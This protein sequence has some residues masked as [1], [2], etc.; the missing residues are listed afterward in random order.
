[1]EEWVNCTPELRSDAIGFCREN[2]YSSA[3]R[4]KNKNAAGRS[5]AF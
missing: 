1:M 4:W 3:D 2:G 5:A